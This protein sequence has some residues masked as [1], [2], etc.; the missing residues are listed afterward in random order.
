M[1]F[2]YVILKFLNKEELIIVAKTCKAAQKE[3]KSFL[4]ISRCL[5]YSISEMLHPKTTNQLFNHDSIISRTI[6]RHIGYEWNKM[7]SNHPLCTIYYYN[8]IIENNCLFECSLC[9]G[10]FCDYRNI[11]E[12]IESRHFSNGTD[13]YN[14]HCCYCG[15]KTNKLY[16]H[17]LKTHLILIC[18]NFQQ[19]MHRNAMFKKRPLNY[20]EQCLFKST[21]N[22]S[23]K[24]WGIFDAKQTL[25]NLKNY[26]FYNEW[27][28]IIFNT[29]CKYVLAGGCLLYCLS[30]K[31]HYNQKHKAD[32]DFFAIQTNFDQYKNSIIDI[33]NN[34]QK[35]NINFLIERPSKYVTNLYINFRL[36]FT[37]FEFSKVQWSNS[38]IKQSCN[39][40]QLI[41]LGNSITEDQLLCK[42][43]DIE[44]S[45][46]MFDGEKI[47][48][49]FAFVES[50]RTET[51]INYKYTNIKKLDHIHKPRSNKYL[52]RGFVNLNPRGLHDKHVVQNEKELKYYQKQVMKEQGVYFLLNHDMQNQRDLLKAYLER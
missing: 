44:A 8:C 26:F 45:Q 52:Q 33:T 30:K 46:I 24:T 23:S 40:M 7:W 6:L 34:F 25:L 14:N 3:I 41:W 49:S 20:M 16:E 42:Y 15:L 5:N 28:N 1:I 29:K 51:I 37:N 43:F 21:I 2:H 11:I 38:N 19:N 27:K 32:M 35:H 31:V 17:V 4:V 39:K 12:H 10:I 50:L 36:N 18:N 13:L 9:N 22:Y 47:L 48:C